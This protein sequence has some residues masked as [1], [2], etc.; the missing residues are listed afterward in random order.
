M[1][2]LCLECAQHALG[3]CRPAGKE[4]HVRAVAIDFEGGWLRRVHVV[5]IPHNASDAGQA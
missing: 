3:G 4:R 2:I 5:Y 1:R